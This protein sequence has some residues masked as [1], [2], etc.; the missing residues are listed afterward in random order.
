M[1]KKWW[2]LILVLILTA[3]AVG[4]WMSCPQQPPTVQTT[5]LTPT[6]VEHT[7]SCNGVVE[8]ADGVGVFAPVSCR[9]REVKVAV[10]QRVKKG[11]VLAVIDKAATLSE[12]GDIATQVTLAA[13]EEEIVAPSDGIVIELS[14]EVGKTLKLGTPCAVLVRPD[15]LRVRIAIREKDLRAL[16]EGMQVRI[17]GDGLD[18]SSYSGVLTEI[19]SAAST[20]SSATVVA[21]V[22]TPNDGVTDTSFRLGLTAKA[23]VI[24]SVTEAGYLVPYEAV[25]ADG[26]GSYFYVLQ[27]GVARLY[28]I[29]AATQVA[30]GWLLT[31]ETLHSA[32]VILEPEKVVADGAEVME[33]VS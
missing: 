28:R 12:S 18:Q 2:I 23:T 29:S 15:D 25:L 9:V 20:G 10:G 19:S 4:W 33:A 26:E 1:V 24:T 14:A 22:V 11:D 17:S 8:A 30:R 5:V 13:M 32:A 31:D 6:M 21:G 16:R 7:V 27:D 3:L